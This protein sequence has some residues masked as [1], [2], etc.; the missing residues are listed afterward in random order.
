MCDIELDPDDETVAKVKIVWVSG[1]HDKV[2]EVCE[3]CLAALLMVGSLVK[4]AHIGA[5]WAN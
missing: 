3:S 4:M 2:A 5:K 1:A